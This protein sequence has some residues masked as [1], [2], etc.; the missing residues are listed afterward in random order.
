M[1]IFSTRLSV[2]KAHNRIVLFSDDPDWHANR[3]TEALEK[4]DTEVVWL[5]FA[6]CVFDTRNG[7]SGLSLPG[8][9]DAL[10]DGVFVRLIDKGSLEQITLRLGLLHGLRELARRSPPPLAFKEDS[11][12]FLAGQWPIAAIA[13]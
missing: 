1:R 9:E 8:F 2:M 11:P 3:L 7:V 13:P 10:P 12:P 6:Q 5:S 4:R